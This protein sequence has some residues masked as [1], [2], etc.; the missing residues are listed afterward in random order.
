MA[1]KTW[2]A[3]KGSESLVAHIGVKPPPCLNFP[4]SEQVKPVSFLKL[5]LFLSSAT[6]KPTDPCKYSER[7]T[8]ISMKYI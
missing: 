3:E 2:N 7:K 8:N 1:N 5:V 4:V 6:Q